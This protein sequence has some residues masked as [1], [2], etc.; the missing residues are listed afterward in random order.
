LHVDEGYAGGVPVRRNPLSDLEYIALPPSFVVR[1][2]PS[3]R[4][5]NESTVK[6][7]LG[8]G[9]PS[10]DLDSMTIELVSVTGSIDWSADSGSY[11]R[12]LRV[13]AQIPDRL[14]FEGKYQNIPYWSS[15]AI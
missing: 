5:I 15:D 9:C 3:G 11:I 4:A 8:V 13:Y 14:I 1:A 2:D 10:W 6:M 7:T 12:T